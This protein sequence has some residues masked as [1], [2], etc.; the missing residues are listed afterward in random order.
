MKIIFTLV[1]P[2]LSLR[3]IS[4]ASADSRKPDSNGNENHFQSNEK[5]CNSHRDVL[6]GEQGHLPRPGSG[7]NMPEA[8]YWTNQLGKYLGVPGAYKPEIGWFKA[9][10][11]IT[12][13]RCPA[14]ED[15]HLAGTPYAGKQGLNYGSNAELT[16]TV[17]TEARNMGWGMRLEAL[18]TIYDIGLYEAGTAAHTVIPARKQPTILAAA[19]SRCTDW[20]APAKVLWPLNTSFG[21]TR[22]RIRKSST[23][24]TATRQVHGIPAGCRIR[25]F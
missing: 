25:D 8:I 17:S 21:R 13:F 23:A 1:D 10:Q 16:I 11:E 20:K 3:H 2:S 4:P 15:N 14:S 12:V 9:E 18:Q 6:R 5:N 22:L 19:D 7:P 24:T